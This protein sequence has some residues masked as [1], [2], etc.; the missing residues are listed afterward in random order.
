MRKAFCDRCGREI[1]E[2]SSIE[3]LASEIVSIFKEITKFE[4]LINNGLNVYPAE[5]C[6]DCQNSLIKW[7]KEGKS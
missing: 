6:Q 1:K 4:L 3:K 5:L 7:F 2:T